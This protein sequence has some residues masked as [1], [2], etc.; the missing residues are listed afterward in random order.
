MAS[1]TSSMAAGWKAALPASTRPTLSEPVVIEAQEAPDVDQ[2]VLLGAHGAA[3]GQGE[4][5]A[6]DVPHLPVRLPRLAQL[7]EVGVLGEAAGVEEQRHTVAAGYLAG[8]PDV[9]QRDRLPA[10]RIVRD[11]QAD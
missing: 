8:R 5:L 4:H 1:L 2:A 6:G 11:G 7:D 10:P 9:L 3:V